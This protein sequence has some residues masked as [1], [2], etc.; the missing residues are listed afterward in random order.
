MLAK[1][2]DTDLLKDENPL[3]EALFNYRLIH[4][5]AYVVHVDMVLQNEVA[6]KLTPESIDALIEYHRDVFTVNMAGNTWEWSEKEL[7]LKALR[8][9]FVQAAN[10][11]VYRTNALALEGMEESGAGELI[12]GR[13]EGVKE[14]IMGLFVPLLPPPPRV[15]EV[16]RPIPI[17]PSSP[18]TGQWWSQPTVSSS[19]PAP[20]DPWNVVPSSPCFNQTNIAMTTELPLT[21]TACMSD[22]DMEA[23]WASIEF[24]EAMTEMETPSPTP[25]YSPPP[26]FLG[27]DGHYY[28]AP[29]AVT[30]IPQIPFSSMFAPQ[31]CGASMGF[32]GFGSFGWD[33]YPETAFTTTII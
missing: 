29:L 31:P 2:P 12:C 21:M 15:V 10:R 19:N 5:D 18:K 16:V 28:E 27:T 4:V 7:Q 6:F 9:E 23:S 8:E 17:L 32:N 13:S 30:P 33:R 25:S 24:H 20:V 22:A 11:F 26:A 3:V 14:A 1:A